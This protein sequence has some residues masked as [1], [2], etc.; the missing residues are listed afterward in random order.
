MP[1]TPSSWIRLLTLFTIASMIEAGF[2]N[3]MNVFT[4]LYLPHLGIAQAD[5]RT[6]TG[7][8]GAVASLV[9][10]PFLPFWGALADRYARQPII[11]RSFV[12]HLLAGTLAL[13]A[14]NIWVFLLARSIM[15]LSL[16][17]SGLM[18][19]T[20]S[21]R[22]PPQ[23]M[24]LAFSI[25]NGGSPVGAFLGPLLGGPI[26]DRY[27]F[28]ALI[29]IDMVLMLGVVLVMAFGY[30][31]AFVGTNRGSLLRMAADSIRIIAHSPRLRALFPAMFLL[32][33]GWQ[34]AFT[35]ISL[36]VAALYHGSDLNTAT[37]W[38][39]GLGGIITL[40]LSPALGAL[41]DRLGYWRV[42]FVMAAAEIVLWPLPALTSDL[43]VFALLW[44]AINGI[45]STV[46]A[47]SFS[48]LAGSALPEVR[49]R[50]MAYA[51]L[52]ANAG[53]LLGSV[54]GTII[55]Q[56]SVFNVFPVAAVWTLLGLAAMIYASRRPL[57]AAP[58]AA[59]ALVAVADD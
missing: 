18:M 34:L 39:V 16:G 19:T 44:A 57:A 47:L 55:T 1:K 15:S 48:V 41:A 23:R 43:M 10:L 28:P 38:V 33:T 8:L 22:T 36:A 7:L 37:G 46:F 12:A 59:G 21:E 24:G 30:R 13:L 25:M 58:S 54:T 11:V 26:V 45:A 17:N 35:Y 5:V 42:L 14:G 27:G 52:P 49:G 6:W 51:F 50:V 20:L 56:S 9:G 31:D 32:F 4:P 53:F 2:W 3:Q 40:V 29:T